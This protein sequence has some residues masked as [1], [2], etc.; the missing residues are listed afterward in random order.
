MLIFDYAYNSLR[1]TY[2]VPLSDYQTKYSSLRKNNIKTAIMNADF[3]SFMY[4]S[5]S[6]EIILSFTADKL[7]P[8]L[9]GDIWLCYIRSELQCESAKQ[10][11]SLQPDFCPNWSIV[12]DYYGSFFDASALLRLTMRGNIFLDAQTMAT[13]KKSANAFLGFEINIDQNCVYYIEKEA[14]TVDRYSLHLHSSKHQTHETVWIETGK[15]IRNMRN[16][17][18]QKSDELTVL[19]WIIRCLDTLGDTFPSQLRNTVNYQLL[20]GLNAVDKKILPSNVFSMSSKWLDP[21]LENSIKKKSP[22]ALK[23]AVFK[24][25]ALYIHILTY[26]LIS[27]YLDMRG[28]GFGIMSALNKHRELKLSKPSAIYTYR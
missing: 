20:Y 12:S 25:Y 23:I 24:S 3:S 2:I 11:Y 28:I 16:E 7:L 19:N 22:D 4:D 9:L 1:Q 8:A 27:E 15:I 5:N 13:L 21:V 14:S 26:N 17:S 18:H 6:K 10:I